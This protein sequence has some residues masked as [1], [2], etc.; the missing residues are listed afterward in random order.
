MI[1]PIRLALPGQT[2]DPV[3][4]ATP[5][6]LDALVPGGG[7][8][9]VEVGFGKGKYLLRRALEEPHVRFLGIEI[10]GHYWQELARRAA[11]R[12]A[13]NLLTARAEAVSFFATCLPR[14][15]ARVVHV[16]FPDPWP[17]TR[18][19][20]RRLFDPERVDLVLGLL[21]PGGE[22]RF[23]TDFLTYGAAVE[24]ILRAH[25]GLEVEVVP[26]LWPEGPRTHY[27]AKYV[28]EGRPILRL[29]AKLGPGAEPGA[30]HPAGERGIVCAIKDGEP[31]AE[32]D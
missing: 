32:A 15:F 17:K 3:A 25:P 20:R 4:I 13:A 27:E 21:E 14:A 12:R 5:Y 18:H 11:R 16:Y 8:W 9:E 23:A 7:P 19:R 2:L 31:T 24:R 26:G 6:D 10:V 30:F 28:E 1:Q 22:L 29:V